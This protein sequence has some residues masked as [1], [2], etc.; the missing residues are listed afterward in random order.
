MPINHSGKPLF[1]QL[2]RSQYAN[3]FEIVVATLPAAMIWRGAVD[4]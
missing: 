2:R 3:R 1:P 4:P